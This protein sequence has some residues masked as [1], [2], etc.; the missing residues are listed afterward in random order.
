[1]EDD[2]VGREEL[3]VARDDKVVK[4]VEGCDLCQRHKN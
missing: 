4:Y 1:M 2:R 3:L